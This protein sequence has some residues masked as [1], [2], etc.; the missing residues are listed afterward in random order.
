MSLQDL[1]QLSSSS[2][3][4]LAPSL[5]EPLPN[6]LQQ[7]L[8]PFASA[9]I[10]GQQS[11]SDF[12]WIV[13][14]GA[15]V[16]FLTAFAIGANDVANTFSSSVGSRAIPLWA[17]IA[18]AAVLETLGATL[19]GGAV[20]DS[21]RSK[22]IDFAVFTDQPSILMT[23]MLCALIGAGLWLFLANHFSLPVSTTHAIIGSLL[24]FGLASGNVHAIRWK[25][26]AFILISW[27]LAPVAASVVGAS[28]FV[29]LRGII[30][31]SRHPLKRA[32]RFL[33]FFIWLITLTFSVFLVFKNF[34]EI[35]VSC[36]QDVPGNGQIEQ[37]PCR[38]AWWADAHPGVAIGISIGI[39]IF[40]T[41]IISFLVYRFA[42][43]RVRAYRKRLNH[44]SSISDQNGS[45]R[46]NGLLG[47]QGGSGVGKKGAGERKENGLLREGLSMM[48]TDREPIM[49][50][51]EGSSEDQRQENG[52]KEGMGGERDHDHDVERHDGG[53]YT[54]EGG[55]H[56][57][58]RGTHR[59]DLDG[60]LKEGKRDEEETRGEVKMDH[61]N[62]QVQLKNHPWIPPG[63][64]KTRSQDHYTIEKGTEQMSDNPILSSDMAATIS[65]PEGTV[66]ASLSSSARETG[67][68]GY[69]S[70]TPSDFDGRPSSQKTSSLSHVRHP[71]SDSFAGG[72]IDASSS[73]LFQRILQS[74]L[75]LEGGATKQ[76]KRTSTTSQDESVSPPQLFHPV[77]VHAAS[78]P[79]YREKKNKKDNDRGDES[80]SRV[81]P[82][83]PT[84]SSYE[85][86]EQDNRGG[87]K[88]DGAPKGCGS[89]RE[90][91]PVGGGDNDARDH[92]HHEGQ[93]FNNRGSKSRET[94]LQNGNKR[95]YEAGE[96]E[97]PSPSSSL[98]RPIVVHLPR[99]SEDNGLPSTS[100]GGGGQ[101]EEWGDE[102]E[103][104]N[105]QKVVRLKDG[106]LTSLGK[107]RRGEP[108]E[109]GFSVREGLEDDDEE[110][111]DDLPLTWKGRL[112]KK[113]L[114]MP[115]FKD[116]HAEG[117][118][119]DELV[120]RLHTG[121]EIFDMETE[122]F[123]SA[124]QVVSACMGCI[125]HSANDTA[126]AIGPFAAILTVYQ[127]G[128]AS[129]E[130][131]SPWYILF[132]GGLSMSLGL[133]LLGYRVIKT[134]GVKLVKITPARGFS[135]ELG[136]AWTVLLFSAV[137]IPLSTTHC[138]V[139]STVGV[140]L[141]EPRSF[142]HRRSGC[143]GA[144][145]GGI[146]SRRHVERE[147]SSSEARKKGFCCHKKIC[148]SSFNSSRRSKVDEHHH[149]EDLEEERDFHP[150]SSSSSSSSGCCA[151]PSGCLFINTTTVNWRLFGGVFVSW[152]VTIAFSAMVSAALFAFA[153]Y[154]P[155]II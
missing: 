68:N 97:G 42:M 149:E 80:S 108:D 145:G 16:C 109:E 139:G 37:Y 88:Y 106:E 101:A 46:H 36:L 34:F 39:S 103:G 152:I 26:V 90:E 43:H 120:A 150:S 129:S 105:G 137:G 31:R 28:I 18:M 123:F 44:M 75:S 96:K 9:G 111:E 27:V 124:C 45:D 114:S 100:H 130:I 50:Y 151:C 21:I 117:G 133:A 122:L 66:S 1:S 76:Q 62:K 127:T 112:K 7:V 6:S 67:L 51:K 87:L 110:D 77:P 30:L 146:L 147:R 25:Q 138:A 65:P 78:P 84:T 118:A 23:G 94:S 48:S 55:V 99:K 135:M 3:A 14:V 54:P 85:R 24:G 141:M 4:P 33:W 134:V 15:V 69:V 71:P 142:P 89:Y 38:I 49:M 148:P 47:K 73:P 35:N 119:E 17:A 41:L 155:H 32:K 126:N 91:S 20:T 113:W 115:W 22:I 107:D 19:L 95:S 143:G 86:E 136:A 70:S 104:G 116:L 13:A 92:S 74:R 140:G 82:G 57:P 98:Y 144:E 11:P 132:F 63:A 29:C 81:F 60:G 58:Y 83:V 125:A 53:G 61:E 121:A 56:T 153:A 154:S 8:S 59:G 10:F 79:S 2:E 102:R 40:L 5:S 131:G 72:E 52:R 93:G 64:K 128:G 12:T